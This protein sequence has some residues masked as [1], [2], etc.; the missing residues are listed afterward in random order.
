MSRGRQRWP[1]VAAFSF[2]V[3]DTITSGAYAF[4]LMHT[5]HTLADRARQI[6]ENSVLHVSM[7][8]TLAPTVKH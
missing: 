3:S 7:I 1:F 2:I 5:I 4:G 8:G 6:N